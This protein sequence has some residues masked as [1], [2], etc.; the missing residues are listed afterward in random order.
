M[1][2]S[3]F[4]EFPEAERCGSGAANSGSEGRA[5][6]VCRRLQPVVRRATGYRLLL[7]LPMPP[8]FWGSC[9]MR[10]LQPQLL[11]RDR[12]LAGYRRPPS[13]TLTRDGVG[14][15]AVSS[16]PAPARSGRQSAPV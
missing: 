3:S 8:R 9:T 11:R 6:A 4:L 7:G 10:R 5:D 14:V 2:V 1:A 15:T 13:T 16:K 12:P